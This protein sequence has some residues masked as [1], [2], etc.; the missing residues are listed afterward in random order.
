MISHCLV[1]SRC[2]QLNPMLFETKGQNKLQKTRTYFKNRWRKQPLNRKQNCVC[3]AP[4][5]G[6]PLQWSFVYFRLFW[7]FVQEGAERSLLT[8]Q[9]YRKIRGKQQRHVPII[10]DLYNTTLKCVW[11]LPFLC[12]PILYFMTVVHKGEKTLQKAKGINLHPKAPTIFYFWWSS[13]ISFGGNLWEHDL[14]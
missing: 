6:V 4:I 9:K 12:T 3:F 14:F 8:V 11:S 7:C 13:T 2:A 1:L 5:L 10:C